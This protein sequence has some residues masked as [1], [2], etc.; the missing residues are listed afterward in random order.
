MT[1]LRNPESI[2]L[3]RLK[4]ILIDLKIPFECV[5][6][7]ENCENMFLFVTANQPEKK[8]CELLHCSGVTVLHIRTLK[9][10]VSPDQVFLVVIKEAG[11]GDDTKTA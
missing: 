10:F 5:D 9:R 3:L 4:R 8:T 6:E 2:E 7:I 1:L 11:G